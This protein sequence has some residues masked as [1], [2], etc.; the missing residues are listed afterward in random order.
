M[1]LGQPCATIASLKID[2]PHMHGW[3]NLMPK[4][5]SPA[6]KEAP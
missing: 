6:A 3:P 2:E 4:E 1:I 5:R